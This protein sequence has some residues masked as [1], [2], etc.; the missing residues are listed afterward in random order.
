MGRYDEAVK[1]CNIALKIKENDKDTLELI[2]W[3][4]EESEKI[5]K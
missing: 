1:C 4:N 5:K 2:K 3:I